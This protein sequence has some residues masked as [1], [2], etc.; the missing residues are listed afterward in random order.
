MAETHRPQELPEH[1]VHHLV[2]VYSSGRSDEAAPAAV[3]LSPAP[4]D[5]PSTMAFEGPL[6]STGRHPEVDGTPLDSHVSAYHH[7]RSDLEEPAI[8]RPPS[9]AAEPGET[10]TTR[11]TSIFKK[12][13]THE[14]EYPPLT[15]GYSI[16]EIIY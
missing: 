8:H 16:L 9:E 5:Y 1:P 3:A 13:T 14:G 15:G 10:L 6:S 11:I 7:W 4:S 12:K 2:S